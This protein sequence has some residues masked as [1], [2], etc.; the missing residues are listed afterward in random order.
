MGTINSAQAL[1][2]DAM[3]LG[4]APAKDDD[5]AR[6]P[7]RP[8]K[9]KAADDGPVTL[10]GVLKKIR[11]LA[12]ALFLVFFITFL[13]FP[14][15]LT[16]LQSQTYEWINRGTWMPVFLVLLFNCSDYVGRQFVAGCTTCSFS[17]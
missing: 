11:M 6:G 4:I 10:L 3:K 8:K 17:K 9:T 7:V 12:L 1:I 14:G 2:T 16:S 15:M 13:P 5:A